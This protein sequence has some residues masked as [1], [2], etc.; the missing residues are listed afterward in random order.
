M[1]VQ[2][3]YLV[4]RKVSDENFYLHK[5]YVDEQQICE[6]VQAPEESVYNP[7]MTIFVGNK[8]CFDKADDFGDD[9]WYID[10][11]EVFGRV[12]G[13]VIIPSKN[14]VY[15]Q[16]DKERKSTIK[17]GDLELF[18]D[19][20]YNPLATNNVVQN[21]EVLSIC[22]KAVDSYFGGELTVEASPGD[23]VYTH[24]FLTHTDNEREFNGV[25]YYEIHYE[26]LYCIIKEG[27]I[28][29]LNDWNFVVPVKAEEEITESG[30]V[31]DFK[32]GNELNIGIVKHSNSIEK[33]EVI[34]FKRGREYRIDVEGITY[35][36][37]ETRDILCKFKDMKAKAFGEIIIVRPAEQVTEKNG[38]MTTVAMNPLPE[39]GD[40]ISVGD[41]VPIL[42]DGE[43]ILFRKA[44][45][46][47]VE[48][49]GEKVLLMSYKSVYARV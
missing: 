10:V 22:D 38:F 13:E 21:G 35:Y 26:N 31:K 8:I 39:K 37:I 11:D 2:S 44:A 49:E 5:F 36:R 17:H 42:K 30:I 28:Q 43:T 9:C 7:E 25:T 14:M 19:T 29:M 23:Q 4:V 20:T 16:A 45:S 48:I 12:E 40:I 47:E 46:T 6:V 3:S 32:V 15:I 41:D 1:I 24:H 34:I 27:S 18:N 33:E